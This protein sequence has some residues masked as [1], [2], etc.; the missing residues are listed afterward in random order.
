[1]LSRNGEAF[2]SI[3]EWRA[4]LSGVSIPS[5][6]PRLQE[7]MEGGPEAIRLARI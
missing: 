3:V 2:R 5:I 7:Y 1:M 4:S 6:I